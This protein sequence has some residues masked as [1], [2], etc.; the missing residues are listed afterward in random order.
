MSPGRGGQSCGTGGL[1]GGGDSTQLG[2]AN[3]GGGGG[4]S[5]SSAPG[6]RQGGSGIVMIRY[7]YQGS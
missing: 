1:G 7:Q 3:T 6:G 5:D 2:V 4:A